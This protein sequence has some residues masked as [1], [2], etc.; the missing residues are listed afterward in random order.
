MIK[1]NKICILINWVREIDMYK[2]LI[3]KLPKEKLIILVND[4]NNEEIERKNNTRE[5][6]IGIKKEKLNYKLY[7]KVYLKE[8]YKVLLSTG[9]SGA[10]KID[11]VSILRFIYSR[12][13]GIIL[14]KTK[15]SLL[16]LKFFGRP[17]VAGGSSSKLSRKYYPEKNLGDC[18]V[19]FPWSMDL[20]LMEFPEKE[21]KD[22][23]DIFFTHGIY[24]SKL[25][26]KKFKN[27]KTI[28][29]GYPR[30][31]NLDSKKILIRKY[32]KKFKFSKNKK[33]I[34]WIPTHVNSPNEI[35]TN[36]IYWIN[37][38]KKLLKN[39]D[40]IVR[41]HT[42]TINYLPS[43]ISELKRKGFKVD[44]K[45]DR[46]IGELFKLSDLVFTDYGG[47]VFSSIY[48]EKPTI[49]LNLPVDSKYL[50]NKKKIVTFDLL[51]RKKISSLKLNDTLGKILITCRNSLKK[52]ELFKKSS[53][54]K[55]YFGNKEK[56]NSL[57]KISKFLLKK[58]ND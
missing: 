12:S 52:K 2:N 58:I 10:K 13:I 29:I 56:I 28:I 34:F 21:W 42:K 20:N 53:I 19:K 30:Y 11:V 46:K 16:L 40:I 1:V 17:F 48:L 37:N 55:S 9:E 23:F 6:I 22:N 25:I 38:F 44:D 33:K 31:N 24:D 45:S 49:L 4:L 41:P 51:V 36:I 35:G 5:I 3:N 18:V 47:S 15:L 50:E 26:N 43:I 54:K 8:K 32:Q 57:E 27:K 39:Y 14:E 7:S